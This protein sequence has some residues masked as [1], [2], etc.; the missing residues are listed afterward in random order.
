MAVQTV[1]KGG[2][3]ALG[4]SAVMFAMTISGTIFYS[5]GNSILQDRLI[6]EL[7]QRVPRV[8]DPRVVI[9]AGAN[10]LVDSMREIYPQYVDQILAAYEAALQRVFLISVVMAC[11]SALGSF[12]IEWK[13]VKN[14]KPAV[15]DGTVVSDVA[16]DEA[17]VEAAASKSQAESNSETA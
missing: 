16:N 12:F 7:R 4:T 9:A 17:K 8:V 1:L 2:D 5:V 11:L 3:I 13:S 14:D 6:H 15:Q 10:G